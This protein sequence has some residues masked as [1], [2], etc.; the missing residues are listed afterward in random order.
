MGIRGILYF[1]VIASAQTLALGQLAQAQETR[2][3]DRDGAS[4]Y[5]QTLNDLLTQSIVQDLASVR[6]ECMAASPVYRLDCIRQGLELTSRRTPYHGDYGPMRD[7]LRSGAVSVAPIIEAHADDDQGRL[8]VKPGSNPRFKTRRYYAAT[9]AGSYNDTKA[10]A[11]KALDA[12]QSRLLDIG[13]RTAAWNKAYTTVSIA[14]ASLADVL[15][16]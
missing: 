15:R 16:K 5:D 2:S 9:K 6:S 7:A 14:V 13:K 4:D 11:F 8:E 1:I 10:D 3:A 12:T